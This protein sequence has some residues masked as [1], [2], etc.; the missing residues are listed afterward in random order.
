MKRI[1]VL[2]G[3]LALLGAVPAAAQEIGIDAAFNSRYE[4]RGVTLT[5]KFVL[6]PDA[7]VTIP[8]G[9]ASITGGGWGNVELVKYDDPNNDISEN[10]YGGAGLTEF[11]W[12]GEV[13]LP[14]GVAT[15][16]AGATGYIYTGDLADTLP[17]GA[18]K[19]M[20]VISDANNTT[21]IYGKLE[22][23]IPLNPSFAIYYDV[24]KVKGAYMEFGVSHGIPLGATELSLGALMGLSAGQ[25]F[26]SSDPSYNFADDG[27]THFDFSAEASFNAGPL[28]I[29]PTAHL[30]WGIDDATKFSSPGHTD[31]DFKF[32]F[33]ASIGWSHAFGGGEE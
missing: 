5:N 8:V 22:V 9:V 16:T 15:L 18:T 25:G 4:W 10:G 20:T 11:D 3:V 27:V 19:S 12:W 6:Q 1:M 2:G 17:G 33:G 28:S 23:G 30:I 32:W 21:E 7:Y 14:V 24:D 31:T 26:S 13:A 29:T